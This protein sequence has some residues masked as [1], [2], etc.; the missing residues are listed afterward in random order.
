MWKKTALL[1]EDNCDFYVNSLLP[2]VEQCTLPAGS[3][4]K[5]MNQIPGWKPLETTPEKPKTLNETM[6]VSTQTAV[7]LAE[8]ADGNLTNA[9][10]LDQTRLNLNQT[11]RRRGLNTNT[12]E[13]MNKTVTWKGGEGD[14]GKLNATVYDDQPSG[15]FEEQ[16]QVRLKKN[17]F[18]TKSMG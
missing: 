10:M 16:V 9:S 11:L 12:L 2:H 8:L 6:V 5:K 14:R 18:T 15:F 13:K 7:L 17:L 3:K 4:I 1:P